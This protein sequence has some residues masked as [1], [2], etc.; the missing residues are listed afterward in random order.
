[1][2][3]GLVLVITDN[4]SSIMAVGWQAAVPSFPFPLSFQV[5]VAAPSSHQLPVWPVPIKSAPFPF[6]S[7]RPPSYKGEWAF[8]PK[9]LFPDL[10]WKPGVLLH[11]LDKTHS[12]VSVSRLFCLVCNSVISMY[13]CSFCHFYLPSW[14]R[15]GRNPEQSTV[16]IMSLCFGKSVL[17]TQL[18]LLPLAYPNQELCV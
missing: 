3:S 18:S 8:P 17:T 7:H 10:P 11:S 6:A 9:K 16:L 12:W 2:P 1:M 5:S 4:V 14:I 13:Y 15:V